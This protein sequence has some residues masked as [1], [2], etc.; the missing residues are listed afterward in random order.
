M[1]KLISESAFYEAVYKLPIHR[2]Q[3]DGDNYYYFVLI[4]DIFKMLEQLPPAQLGTD[5]AEVGTDCIRRQAAIDLW[6]KYHP[7]IA[8]DA[9]QYDA[10]LRQLPPIQP[11]RGQWIDVD[12]MGVPA[13]ACDQCNTFFPLAYTGGGHHYCPNCGAKMEVTE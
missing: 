3:A 1:D 9:M 12:V 13:Q 11:K 5:L 8:V 2:E 6:E 7:T 10:E 4:A